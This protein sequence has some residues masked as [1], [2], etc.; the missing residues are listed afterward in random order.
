MD[1]VTFVDR[2][3]TRFEHRDCRDVVREDAKRACGGAHVNL[4]HIHVIIEGLES[5]NISIKA[6]HPVF[7]G[8]RR[9][10]L[11]EEKVRG[12]TLASE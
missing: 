4:L 3:Q 12:R 10:F 1:L 9:A 11:G 5:K 2:D 6:H 8:T 7:I